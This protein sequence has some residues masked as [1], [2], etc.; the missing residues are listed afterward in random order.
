LKGPARIKIRDLHICLVFK[1]SQH[2]EGVVKTTVV[3]IA[4]LAGGLAFA[5]QKPVLLSQMAGFP[6]EAVEVLAMH[7]V[8]TDREFL[9]S[10]H[11]NPA[12]VA[13]ALQVAEE[14]VRSTV[15]SVWRVTGSEWAKK[16]ANGCGELVHRG[17]L[18]VHYQTTP[19]LALTALSPQVIR[20]LVKWN[21]QTAEALYTTCVLNPDLISQA[22]GTNGQSIATYIEYVQQ[23]APHIVGLVTRYTARNGGEEKLK[24]FLTGLAHPVD[25]EKPTVAIGSLPR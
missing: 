20:R 10:G 24:V 22:L 21:I 13:A 9:I 3:L 6:A 1:S 5:A 4:W 8:H 14:G 11:V 12:G 25:E 19:L 15:A 18:S 17:S 23:G 2:Y 7:G 16:W